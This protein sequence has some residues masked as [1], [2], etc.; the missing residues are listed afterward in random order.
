[1]TS[2]SSFANSSG[3]S[4]AGT[5][6]VRSSNAS[7]AI[8]VSPD[9]LF[10]TFLT[11]TDAIIPPSITSDFSGTLGQVGHPVRRQRLEQ[12]GVARQGVARHIKAEHLL[13]LGQ[14][15]G[16]G[17]LGNVGQVQDLGRTRRVAVAVPIAPA[18]TVAVAIAG[19]FEE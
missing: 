7:F 1:M 16:V 14:P 9:R 6:P 12:A 18:M 10:C 17:Q 2:S 13:F 11:C 8:R 15:L 19:I 5:E 3:Q 4:I